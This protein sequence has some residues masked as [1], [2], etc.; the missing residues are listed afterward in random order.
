MTDWKQTALQ[1]LEQW[2]NQDYVE[3]AILTGSRVTKFH[4][5]H[6]DIDIHIV[7]S[8]GNKW[9]ERGNFV[10]DG[11]VVEY[12][13]NPPSMIRK[14]MD[15][16]YETQRR[17]DARMF[18][19]GEIVFDRKGA[20]AELK[21]T[22]SEMIKKKFTAPS[23]EWAETARYQIWDMQDNL[24]SLYES[25]D[26]AFDIYYYS[27]IS[28]IYEIYCK[29]N[30]EEIIPINKITRYVSNVDY[31]RAY[32]FD[33]P[34]D[35]EFY[36]KMIE[37]LKAADRKVKFNQASLLSSYVLNKMNGFDIDGWRFRTPI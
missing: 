18:S 20:V 4:D 35:M 21:K 13:A 30:G 34:K 29:W 6:S 22:A 36:A 10:I 32:L 11:Y 24:A 3:G 31:R 5:S 12:F 9:R 25:G 2:M 8:E 7:L 37:G 17:T 1:F 33:P 27:I 14:Y 26:I 15:E 28:K 23:K 16:D 19:M